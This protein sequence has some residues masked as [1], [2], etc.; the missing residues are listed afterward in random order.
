MTSPHNK[1][2]LY[3]S[4]QKAGRTTEKGLLNKNPQSAQ[5]LPDVT[6]GRISRRGRRGRGDEKYIMY[7]SFRAVTSS[8]EPPAYKKWLLRDLQGFSERHSLPGLPGITRRKP[9][10]LRAKAPKEYIIS[11]ISRKIS[12]FPKNRFDHIVPHTPAV[13]FLNRWSPVDGCDTIG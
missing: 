2:L 6:V 13:I 10:S 12:T 5:G 3:K 1:A 11:V 9:G 8:S 7:C 4:R